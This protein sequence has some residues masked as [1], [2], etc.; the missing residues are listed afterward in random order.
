M[1]LIYIIAILIGT[2]SYSC[3]SKQ[4]SEQTKTT[5]AN[6]MYL[7]VQDTVA[8]KQLVNL[9]MGHAKAHHIDSAVGLLRH[10]DR[11]VSTKPV[12]LN[13][14]ACVKAGEMLN[15]Y[16]V[17]DYFLSYMAFHNAYHNEVLCHVKTTN[18]ITIKLRFTPV[19][20]FG[21][22]SLCLKGI[23]NI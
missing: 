10:V 1:K 8:V 4:K 11:S 13:E 16:P 21:R 12:L 22:W 5:P 9:F 6:E 18:G 23:D 14:A 19:R 3:N 15:K 7:T 20:Y 17:L 2:V